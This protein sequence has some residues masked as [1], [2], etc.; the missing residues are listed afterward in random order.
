MVD[1]SSLTSREFRLNGLTGGTYYWRVRSTARSGQSTNW[2]DPWKISVIRSAGNIEIEAADWGIERVGG[3][4]YIVK[5]KTAPGM[6]VRSQGRTA[7]AGPDGT[8]RL[9]ISAAA[10]ETKVEIGD[11]KGNR[12]GFVLSLRTGNLLGRY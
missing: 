9:Q 11:D 8:F 5:G 7:F 4:I 12:S 2:N 1:R 3:N 10:S 6:V